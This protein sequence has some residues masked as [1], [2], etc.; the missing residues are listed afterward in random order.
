VWQRVNLNGEQALLDVLTDLA[1]QSDSLHR[2]LT[3]AAAAGAIRVALEEWAADDTA[4]SPGVLV[5]RT[6]RE[7]ITGITR[8]DPAG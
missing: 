2:R 7:L 4:D 3:A 5:E 6:M 1:P 8:Y